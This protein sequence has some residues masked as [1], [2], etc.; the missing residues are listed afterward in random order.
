[1]LMTI[2]RLFRFTA[3]LLIAVP[4]LNNLAFAAK[5]PVDAAAMKGKVRQR[6]VGRGV[7]ATLNDKTEAKGLIVSVGEQSFMLKSNGADQPPE[8][9]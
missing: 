3:I 7:R 1:M 4:M 6:G 2:I 9:Q 5:K 8:I